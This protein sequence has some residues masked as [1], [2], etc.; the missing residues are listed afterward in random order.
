MAKP[1][2]I[3]ETL[4]QV[5]GVVDAVGRTAESVGGIVNTGADIAED[6]ARG[7]NAIHEEQRKQEAFDLQQWLSREGFKRGDNRI[8]MLVIGL[9]ALAL[10]LVLVR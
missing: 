10:V 7:R 4:D 9:G 3:T 1:W 6:I 5:T 2:G 8:Q